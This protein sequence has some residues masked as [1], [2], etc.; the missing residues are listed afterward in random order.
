MQG[1]SLS[2][3]KLK[4]LRNHLTA[5]KAETQRSGGLGEDHMSNQHLQRLPSCFLLR[6]SRTPAAPT[7]SIAPSPPPPLIPQATGLQRTHKTHRCQHATA[8]QGLRAGG[9]GSLPALLQPGKT[10]APGGG[11]SSMRP[12]PIQHTRPQPRHAHLQSNGGQF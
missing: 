6:T 5:A 8:G 2:E 10:G 11:S 7:T 3:F 1:D 9:T 4:A 12:P